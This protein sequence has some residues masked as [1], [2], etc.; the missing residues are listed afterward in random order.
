MSTLLPIAIGKSNKGIPRLEC[1]DARR[2][3]RLQLSPAA[4]EQTARALLERPTPR[5][6]VTTRQFWYI[7]GMDLASLLERVASE[8]PRCTA[9]SFGDRRI[10]YAELS[11]QVSRCASGFSEMGVGRGD[12]FGLVMRNCPEFVIVYYALVRLGAVPVPANFLLKPLELR[13]ILEHSGAVGVATQSRYLD[14]V[15]ESSEGLPGFRYMVCCDG[16]GAEGEVRL[17]DVLAD[18][19]DAFPP[20]ARP[21]DVACILYTSGTTGKPKG[22]MLTHRNLTA[23]VDSCRRAIDIRRDD[24]FMCLLPMF[25]TFAWTT[26]VL[27]PLSLGN[28]TVV[29]ES[30]QPFK[31]VAAQIRK[32]KVTLLIAVPPVFAAMTRVPFWRPLRFLLPLRLCVSGAAPLPG[33]VLERFESKFGVP[34]LEGYGLTET[35]PVVSLNPPGGERRPGTVGLE[36]PDVEVKIAG[37]DGTQVRQADVGEI[38]VRGPNVMLGYL[39]DPEATSEAIDCDGWLHTGD[40]GRRQPGGYIEIVDRA[41]DLIIVKGLNVYPREVEDV[42]LGHPDLA[43][44]A[45]IGVPDGTGD[46]LI[47]AFVVPKEGRRIDTS[48]LFRLCRG[49]LAPYKMPKAILVASFLPKN[50]IGKVLKTQLREEIGAEV[51]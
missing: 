9:M 36:I 30:I 28:P 41:K 5:A 49:Q 31:E 1:L 2:R 21:D 40:L 46:E 50:P 42:L 39:H 4:A 7:T 13:Y 38:C 24:V 37:P 29:V 10:S 23:N 22:V 33:A 51:S 12:R 19:A 15:R 47:K 34:L 17:S 3:A 26:C 43:E 45:V 18:A 25:H 27:L 6:V 48:E 32:H 35:S 16:E 11:E 20:R 8:R 44:A 14:C